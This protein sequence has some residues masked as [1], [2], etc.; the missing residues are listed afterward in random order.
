MAS[1]AIS[2][3]GSKLEIGSTDASPTYTRIR[4]F[5]SFTGFDGQASE[6]DATDLESKAKEYLLGLQDAGN[7]NFDLNVN[8]SDPGQIALEAARKSGALR[9]F[10][11]TLPDGQVAT[12]SGLVKSTPLQGGVD[13][14]LTGTVNTRISGE[15]IWTE[16]P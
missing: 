7:F 2:A 13:A 14:I 3:Q 8:R 12:W 9:S 10:R 5:K 4:G 11:L 6:L 16:T 15:V 1:P